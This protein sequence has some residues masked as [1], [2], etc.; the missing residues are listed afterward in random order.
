LTFKILA[1]ITTAFSKKITKLPSWERN[2]V[3]LGIRGFGKNHYG[4]SNSRGRGREDWN[5]SSEAPSADVDG[6]C[7]RQNTQPATAAPAA[8]PQTGRQGSR[9]QR[10]VVHSQLRRWISMNLQFN[11]TFAFGPFSFSMIFKF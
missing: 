5:R 6:R 3:A 9:L 10:L 2:C 1:D 8:L 7:R 11:L 4:F